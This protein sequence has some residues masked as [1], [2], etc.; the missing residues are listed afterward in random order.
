MK[1]LGHGSDLINQVESYFKNQ[2][3]YRLVLTTDTAE[4]FYFKHG[5]KLLKSCKAK[6][7]DDVFVKI[8]LFLFE[9]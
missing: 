5:Y 4:E 9:R 1:N 2:E 7:G 8:I 6:N 3:I